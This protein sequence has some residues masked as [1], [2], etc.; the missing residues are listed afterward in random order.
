MPPPPSPI[1]K[2]LRSL[3]TKVLLTALQSLFHAVISLAFFVRNA[4]PS[5]SS[6]SKPI[7]R[8]TRP[9]TE[10]KA[11]SPYEPDRKLGPE[12]SQDHM[13]GENGPTVGALGQRVRRRSEQTVSSL[14]NID[15]IL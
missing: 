5:T 9:Q 8:D 1:S 2:L 7:S 15:E 12:A 10:R 13:D 6:S 3:C 4:I 14:E 11:V